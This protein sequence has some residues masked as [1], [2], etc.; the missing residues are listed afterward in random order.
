[1]SA[2]EELRND[3]INDLVDTG[4]LDQEQI[5]ITSVDL[6]NSVTGQYKITSE[7]EFFDLDENAVQSLV[8][9]INDKSAF[10]RLKEKH[11]SIESVPQATKKQFSESDPKPKMIATKKKPDGTIVEK[12]ETIRRKTGRVRERKFNPNDDTDILETTEISAEDEN[13][14]KIRETFFKDQRRRRVRFK[15]NNESNVLETTE[16]SAP[17]QTTGDVTTKVT[18]ADGSYVETVKDSSDVVKNTTEASAPD[19]TTGNVN[20][21][22]TD[23]VTG[24]TTNDVIYSEGPLAVDRSIHFEDYTVDGTV[25]GD[26]GISVSEQTYTTT[27]VG[28]VGIDE[29]GKKY[30]EMLNGQIQLPAYVDDPTAIAHTMY[31]VVRSTSFNDVN[32]YI[33]KVATG[34]DNNFNLHV[35]QNTGLYPI[36]WPTNNNWVVAKDNSFSPR[37]SYIIIMMKFKYKSQYTYDARMQ[38]VSKPFDEIVYGGYTSEMTDLASSSREISTQINIGTNDWRSTNMHLYEYGLL[39]EYVNDSKFDNILQTIVNKYFPEPEPE[40]KAFEDLFGTGWTIVEYLPGNTGHWFPG[41]GNLEGYSGGEFLFTTGDNSRWL[42]AD[43]EQV[44]G[45]YDGDARTI[46]KSSIKDIINTIS[47]NKKISK[48]EIYDFCLKLKNET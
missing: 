13:G 40:V 16:V 3:Y 29:N 18:Q 15:A 8:T 31:F 12:V 19:T 30:L 6:L 41:S 9:K 38:F 24:E 34:T 32:G 5:H 26:N 39:N 42:I 48:K 33:N 36:V 23:N 11:G 43:H 21:T 28:K 4:N 17:D 47:K 7:I 10:T 1:M 20:I 35:T 44:N 25:I 22:I 46:K 27:G 14:D 37:E 45:T 2:E